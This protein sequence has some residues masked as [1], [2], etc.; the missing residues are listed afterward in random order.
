[1]NE[2]LKDFK[3]PLKQH[4]FLI[5]S[6]MFAGNA[7]LYFASC[8]LNSC[9]PVQ[10]P[11]IKSVVRSRVRM[12]IVPGIGYQISSGADSFQYQDAVFPRTDFF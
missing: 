10:L 1:M 2:L 8:I 4:S 9:T 12:D 11:G 3:M 6:R 5:Y 7:D